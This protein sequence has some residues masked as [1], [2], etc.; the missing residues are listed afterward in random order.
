MV[1]L[2][3]DHLRW[4]RPGPRRG[5]ICGPQVIIRTPGLSFIELIEAMQGAD[6]KLGVVG[7]DQQRKLDLGGGDRA[8]VDSLLRQRL[9]CLGSD[10]GVAAHANADH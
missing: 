6:G 4:A 1:G 5:D 8:D 3:M 2:G 10:T 9:E 7:I